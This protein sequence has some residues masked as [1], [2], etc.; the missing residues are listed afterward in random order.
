V[1]A[2]QDGTVRLL[3]VEDEAMNRVLLREAI[4]RSTDARLRAIQVRE[5]GDLAAARA[6]LGERI[7]DLVI[8]D[9]RLPD[10]SGLDLAREVATLPDDERPKVVIMS[11]S[12]LPTER[13]AAIAAGCDAFMAKPFRMADL[14]ETLI[15]LLG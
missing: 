10:G 8:L 5:V 9:I 2:G 15:R 3:L 6:V 4:R 13:D 7:V 1:T 11:A 12:V 14:Y